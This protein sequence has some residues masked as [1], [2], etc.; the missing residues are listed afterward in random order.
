MDIW[1]T[2]KA[3]DPFALFSW[4]LRN[5]DP[6]T[7]VHPLYDALLLLTELM[8]SGEESHTRNRAAYT[9]GYGFE[10]LSEIDL[11]SAPGAAEAAGEGKG[12]GGEG[13]GG[14][15]KGGEGKGG[16]EGEGKYAKAKQWT[17]NLREY[18]PKR[19]V[20]E[21][22]YKPRS[23][24]FVAF[25]FYL[26]AAEEGNVFAMTAVA[27]HYEDRKLDA[28]ACQNYRQIVKL[29]LYGPPGQQKLTSRL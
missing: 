5:L 17:H 19:L 4:T 6:A 7:G 10:C 11:I 21:G 13:K 27:E 9:I 15:G 29:Q 2:H 12:K 20:A 18:H 22:I 16:K 25:K 8:M 28:I 3:T 1:E 24:K 23:Y 14:E 26:L